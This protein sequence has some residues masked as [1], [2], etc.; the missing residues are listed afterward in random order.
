MI[1]D[2]HSHI[3]GSDIKGFTPR[4][5]KVITSRLEKIGI[6]FEGQVSFF[7]EMMDRTGVDKLLV[8]ANPN[9]SLYDM[10]KPHS[11]RFIPFAAVNIKDAKEAATWRT[12][13]CRSRHW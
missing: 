10:I 1:I 3:Y 4:H 13:L 5:L 11:E 7:L 12:H 9:V 6:G 2:T 8:F